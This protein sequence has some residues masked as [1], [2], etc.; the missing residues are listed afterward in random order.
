MPTRRASTTTATKAMQK[1]VWAMMTVT[2]PRSG[3]GDQTAVARKKELQKTSPCG[4]HGSAHAVS[5]RPQERSQVTKTGSS[6]AIG[7]TSRCA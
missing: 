1:V 7:A 6:T 4:G 5:T 2:M 3:A